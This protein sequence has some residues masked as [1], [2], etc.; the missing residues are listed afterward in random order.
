MAKALIL[1]SLIFVLSCASYK[2]FVNEEVASTT[3]PAVSVEKALYFLGGQASSDNE[4]TKILAHLREQLQSDGK[5][6]NLA[7]VGNLTAKKGLSDSLNDDSARARASLD[8]YIEL[9]NATGGK[10]IITTGY[11]DWA[12]GGLRG[13]QHVLNLEQ[14]LENEVD[15]G[16]VYLPTGACPGPEEIYLDDDVVVMAINTQWMIH[17]WQKPFEAEGCDVKEEAD[18]LLNLD[19]ALKQNQH[20]KVVI[21]GSHPIFSN[22]R[23]GGHYSLKDH[24]LPPVASSFFI[25]T[26]QLFGAKPDLVNPEYRQFRKS[27]LKILNQYQHVVYLSGHEHSLQYHQSGDDHF[28]ISGSLG[29]S[30]PV[31]K[32]KKANY[33]DPVRGY[34]KLIFY[35]NDEVGVEFWRLNA[36]EME[37]SYS[38]KLYTRKYQTPPDLFQ[39]HDNISYSG[40]TTQ[41]TANSALK[42]RSKRPF[43]WGRNYRPEWTT[44]LNNVPIFDIGTE[45]GGLRIIKKGGGAQTYSLRLEDSTGRQYVLRSIRKYPEKALENA[46]H[47]TYYSDILKDQISSSHP[48]GALA[49]PK[50]A[51]AI[52]VYHT[53]P[54]LVYLPDDPRLGVFRETMSDALYIFEERPDDDW[55]QY[56]HFGNSKNIVSSSNVLR[57]IQNGDNNQI[58]QKQVLRSRLFD[59]LLGDW[60]RHD[61]QWRWASYKSKDSTNYKPIPRDRDQ[62]FYNNDGAV[63]K[64]GS[65]K[66]IS[67]KI[68]G[69]HDRI[70]FPEHLAGNGIFFDRTFLN[71]LQKED[72]V[73]VAR[74]IQQNLT[75]DVIQSALQDLPEG[76][77]TFSNTE[78]AA[79]LKRRRDDLEKYA[80]DYY[81]FMAKYVEVPATKKRDLFIVERLNDN[82]T[83]VTLYRVNKKGERKFMNYDRVFY[84]AETKEIRLFGLGNDD[85][86]E[87]DGQV[88][89]GPKIRIISGTGEDTVIDNS[90]VKKNGKHTI[91]HD[92]LGGIDITGKK[93]VLFKKVTF[94][95]EQRYNR[96][97]FKYN[98][99]Y[100][101]VFI[102]SNPDDGVFIGGGFGLQKYGFRK[103]PGTRH[104]FQ[105]E[106]APKS[107]SFNVGYSLLINDLWRN[108]NYDMQLNIS[109]PSFSDFFYGIGNKTQLDAG[110][111]NLDG[112]FYRARYSQWSVNPG[113]SRVFGN[114]RQNRIRVGVRFRS[115][116]IRTGDNDSNSD[117]FILTYSP[118]V[119]NGEPLLD[120]RR[121]H[122]GATL[123][124]AIDTR[125]NPFTPNRGFVLK[126]GS[127]L[128]WQAGDEKLNYQQ[129]DGNFSFYLGTGGPFDPV[130]ATRIGGVLTFGDYQ[131]YQGARLGGTSNL[132]GYRKARFVGDESIY[133]NT[134]LRIKL[135]KFKNKL[136]PGD[137]GL[138]G[139]HDIGRVWTSS[140]DTGLTDNSLKKWHRGY[141]GGF[142]LSPLGRVV[143]TVELT[144]SVDT[145]GILYYTRLGFMF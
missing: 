19:N 60:D 98:R 47:G 31:V 36:G 54:K 122:F 111:R 141:G 34:G 133:Q 127:R 97:E 96:K 119:L 143:I 1:S 135:F 121:N 40:E 76:I 35:S 137:F 6:G 29:S 64:V 26:R 11:E 10:T 7:L 17:G 37:M 87:L 110:E 88:N 128:V 131:F 2:P 70:K 58:D 67:P 74:E 107:K 102:E 24:L 84:S 106:M 78:L 136:F 68:R 33:A 49:I 18:F 3:S 130:L 23:Y 21:V 45:K 112:Q 57:K 86:F 124:Y 101:L 132:R 123:D 4:G 32:S 14:Y 52:G 28:L 42:R 144:R 73:A 140:T 120:R 80:L 113:L 9:L 117:R 50:M 51:D 115:V 103:N 95:E 77:R 44:T 116:K 56:G 27:L 134:E 16:N 83:R 99:L 81:S 79:K 15:N 114:N 22:G 48:F 108:W 139:F 89:R 69:F 43:L 25:A 61:D 72:W 55:S 71:E 109:E 138:V 92:K 94:P 118:A 53:N 66:W 20:K 41:A 145:G 39:L 85:T 5:R 126:A 38:A 8:Q 100:P 82:E 129:V 105:A 93:E 90:D 12:A 125:N 13:Y 46:L 104:V 91:V 59:L 65:R 30:T 63:V 62:V 75:D 142:W